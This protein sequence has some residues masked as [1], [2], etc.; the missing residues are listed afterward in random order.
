MYRRVPE[1]REGIYPT[2]AVLLFLART[3]KGLEN[4]GGLLKGT[5]QGNKARGFEN[6]QFWFLSVFFLD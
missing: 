1:G 3:I 4:T 6:K 2:I 5:I